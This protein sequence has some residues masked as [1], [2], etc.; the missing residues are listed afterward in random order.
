MGMGKIVRGED[1]KK[2]DNPGAT[3]ADHDSRCSAIMRGM[4]TF[5]SATDTWLHLGQG[6]T[7]WTP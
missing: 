7:P 4:A 6:G 2:D 1:T 3:T 5:E